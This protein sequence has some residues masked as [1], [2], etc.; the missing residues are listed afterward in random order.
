MT[1]LKG[2]NLKGQWKALNGERFTITESIEI[3]AQKV[4][5]GIVEGTNRKILFTEDGKALFHDIELS[6]RRLGGEDVW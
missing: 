6:E 1:G 5:V 4:W 3:P 2:Q